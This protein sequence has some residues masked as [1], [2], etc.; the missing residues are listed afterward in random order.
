MALL[1]Q[2]FIQPQTN[3]PMCFVL[4][5]AATIK[6]DDICATIERLYL[7]AILFG[8]PLIVMLA[9]VFLRAEALRVFWTMIEY[10]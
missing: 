10:V 3:S 8:T 5:N 1:T 6:C 7:S 4:V 2:H 9:F